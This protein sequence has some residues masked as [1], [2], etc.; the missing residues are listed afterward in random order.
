LAERVDTVVGGGGQAGLAAS[1][2]LTRRGI[3]HVVEEL[4]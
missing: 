2:H 4:F 3:E 1:W